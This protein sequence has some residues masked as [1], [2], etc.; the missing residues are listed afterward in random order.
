MKLW[1]ASLLCLALSPLPGVANG[2]ASAPLIV[3][4]EFVSFDGNCDKYCWYS[5]RV[6]SA[7][8]GDVKPGALLHVAVLSVSSRIP[9][10]TCILHLE[11]YNRQ[12]EQ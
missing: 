9:F 5:V 12:G 10:G 4:A 7:L 6:T 3:R 8:H 11:P 1:H 2:L